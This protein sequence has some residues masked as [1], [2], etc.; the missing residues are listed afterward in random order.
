MIIRVVLALILCAHTN[1]VWAVA[2]DAIFTN[3]VQS[4]ASGGSVTF[5]GNTIVNGGKILNNGLRTQRKTVERENIKSSPSTNNSPPPLFMYKRISK[6]PNPK[7]WDMLVR[8]HEHPP[9]HTFKFRIRSYFR[10]NRH[11]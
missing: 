1:A 2:C 10:C 9:G 5:G 11:F 8:G 4:H 7:P 3:G 6:P